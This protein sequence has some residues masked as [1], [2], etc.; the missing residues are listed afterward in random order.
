[1]SDLEDGL[2]LYRGELAEA[3]LATPAVVGGFDPDDD[4]EA[5]LLPCRSVVSL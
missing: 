4:R 2:E 1:M 3:A 5:Q